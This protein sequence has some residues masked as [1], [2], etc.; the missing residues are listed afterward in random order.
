ME[1]GRRVTDLTNVAIPSVKRTE[2]YVTNF[3]D[4][5]NCYFLCKSRSEEQI[6]QKG[7]STNWTG[8]ERGPI[9]GGT[10]LCRVG[11][12]VPEAKNMGEWTI[13]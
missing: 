8:V 3:H 5:L 10:K 2:L 13:N 6:S 1:R 4:F 12:L 9:A 11:N 7:K